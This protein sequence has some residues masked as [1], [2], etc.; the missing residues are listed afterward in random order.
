MTSIQLKIPEE[1]F[2]K[3]SES[4]KERRDGKLVKIKKITLKSVFRV[5]DIVKECPTCKS[6][7]NQ[8]YYERETGRE[9]YHMS[10][11]IVCP[12]VF[13]YP[14]EHVEL[15]NLLS[16]LNRINENFS[17]LKEVIENPLINKSYE[18]IK[19]F[20]KLGYDKVYNEY[21]GKVEVFTSN[22]DPNIKWDERCWE[23]FDEL[24]NFSNSPGNKS[25]ADFSDKNI[26]ITLRSIKNCTPKFEKDKPYYE[27]DK[28]L[29]EYLKARTE[30][31]K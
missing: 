17:D 5:E 2:S 6:E 18:E 1:F 15:E 14:L 10:M 27:L 7:T 30:M 25:W 11:E 13:I 4:K 19:E 21:I 8:F 9:S 22:V 16:K 29:I 20:H 26:N 28:R 31:I 23:V 12:G 24:K 3:N